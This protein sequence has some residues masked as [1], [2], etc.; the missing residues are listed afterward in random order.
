MQEFDYINSELQ[1][2]GFG[3]I[4][5]GGVGLD[6]LRKTAQLSLVSQ[7][8]PSLPALIQFLEI[9]T[10]QEYLVRRIRDLEKGGCMSEFKWNGGGSY[11]EKE[12]DPSLPTDSAVSLGTAKLSLCG[13]RYMGCPVKQMGHMLTVASLVQNNPRAILFYPQLVFLFCH[14][15]GLLNLQ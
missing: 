1:K 12:W 7:H 14:F 10:N 13:S 9:T 11:N 6:R 3:D 4:S 2:H 15:N 8:I 5:V